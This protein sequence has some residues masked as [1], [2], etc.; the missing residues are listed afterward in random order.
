MDIDSC[1][2]MIP[3]YHCP[4]QWTRWHS[5]VPPSFLESWPDVRVVQFKTQSKMSLSELVQRRI[6]PTIFSP[7]ESPPIKNT[8]QSGSPCFKILKS[9]N[10]FNFS[11]DVLQLKTE[12]PVKPIFLQWT[13]KFLPV[14][15]NSSFSSQRILKFQWQFHSNERDRREKK[16]HSGENA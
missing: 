5:L 1:N 10:L 6:I 12:L 3:P 13:S 11:K 16:N 14:D 7:K 2:C 9:L 15:D 8:D 4:V